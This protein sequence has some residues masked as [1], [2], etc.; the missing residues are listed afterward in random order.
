MNLL[1]LSLFINLCSLS[2]SVSLYSSLY[3]S[4]CCVLKRARETGSLV[5]QNVPI[6]G[7]GFWSGLSVFFSEVNRYK[8][9][10]CEAVCTYGAELPKKK[11]NAVLMRYKIII[12]KTRSNLPAVSVV[13]IPFCEA[14]YVIVNIVHNYYSLTHYLYE[15]SCV[16]CVMIGVDDMYAC[17]FHDGS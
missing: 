14:M 2:F 3:S 8:L 6:D 10:M 1:F 15:Y 4:H 16:L 7:R 11:E 13:S 5:S 12:S 9:I 17:T